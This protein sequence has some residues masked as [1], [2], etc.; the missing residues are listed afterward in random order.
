MQSVR[1]FLY[2][3]YALIFALFALALLKYPGEGYIYALFSLA[4]NT[5]LYFGFRKNAIFFDTFIGILFW[6]GFWLKLSFRV[7]FME[8]RFYEATGKFDGTGA[9]FDLALLVASCGILGL[10]AVSHIRE[11]LFFVYPEKMSGTSQQGLL[12]LYQRHRKS[13]LSGFIL[14]IA[15]IA[16]T[17]M[18]FGI[19]QR[20]EIPKTVLPYG[21]GGVYSWLLLF[22]LASCS[23]LILHFEITLRRNISYF[24]ISLSLIENFISNVSLLSSGMLLNSSAIAY[25]LFKNLKLN[26]IQSG[27]RFWAASFIIFLILFGSSVVLVNYLRAGSADILTVKNEISVLVLDRWVG[28]EG[29]MAVT[30]SPEQGWKLW[31]E[32]W[33]EKYSNNSTSFYDLNLITSPY[34]DTDMTKHHYVSLPGILAFCFYPGSFLFLFTCMFLLGAIAT[35]VEIAVF[36]L[37]G[38]NIILCA[39]LAQVVAYRYAHFGYVPGQSYL[40]FGAVFL[41]LFIIYFSNKFLLYWSKRSAE[42]GAP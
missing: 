8:G 23:A 27:F 28:I 38:E 16:A 22:G 12:N 36:K 41:N 32:A 40:L 15:T 37:G 5:L 1:Y 13:V 20:G 30:S 11:R 9:A 31:N 42:L 17:N 34:R 29:V 19:Y 7:A 39:L 25:G 10:L 21:I 18:Y 33:K 35:A 6:L 2:C 14:L 26:F 24:V 4:S 3:L